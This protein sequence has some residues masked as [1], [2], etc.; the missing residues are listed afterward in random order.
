M[1]FQFIKD[2]LKHRLT[3]KTRHGTHSPFVYKLADEVIYDFTD[4]SEYKNIEEQ[5]KKLFNDDS[6]ITVTDLGAGSH[7][8]KNRTKKISQIAKN[9]LKSP[10]LAKLIYRLAKHTQ[11]KSAIELGTCLG[12]T[13]A[14][15]AKTDTQTEVITIEGCPQTA[16]VAKKNFQELNLTNIELHV[17]N[18]DVILPDIIANQPGLDFVYIDGNHRKE[19]T[20]NYFK[21]CLPKVNENSLLIFDD[22]YWSEGM[23]EAWAEIKNHPDVTVTVDLFWIGLVYFKKGQAKEHFKL[24]F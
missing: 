18:F 7:L 21:W 14:Y 12:I 23:K 19:A 17:G 10:R 13:T 4:K 3:A 22:I 24:K 6:I 20:L 15:L 5:R 8:N 16:E 1:L 2:Y 9:A 11:P